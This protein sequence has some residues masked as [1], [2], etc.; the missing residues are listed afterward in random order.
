MSPVRS[1]GLPWERRLPQG[2]EAL[3]GLAQFMRMLW[4]D[5][6]RHELKK[7]GKEGKGR[8]EKEGVRYMHMCKRSETREKG[9]NV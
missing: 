3:G 9:H 1:T 4:A 2:R 8:P 5:A 6:V 7:A